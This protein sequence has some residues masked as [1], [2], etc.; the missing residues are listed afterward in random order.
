[1]A[2]DKKSQFVQ[3][4]EFDGFKESVLTA[5]ETGFEGVNNRLD[6]INGRVGKHDT[7]IFQ[8]LQTCAKQGV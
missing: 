5:V 8:L 3:T 1:M 2:E 6:Q 4:R 7:E